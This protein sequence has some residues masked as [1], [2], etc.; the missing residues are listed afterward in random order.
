MNNSD[1]S[2]GSIDNKLLSLISERGWKGLNEMQEQS[3]RKIIKGDNVLIMAPT[4]YGKTEAAL[5]PIFS[6]ALK[7]SPEPVFLLYITPMRALINDLMRR[8]NWWCER[9]SFRVGRKH[10]EVPQSEKNVRLKEV[11]H[12]LITT[13]EGLEI[14]LDWAPKFREKLKKVK[15]V[16]IDEVHEIYQS[17]RGIQLAI[18]LKRLSSL[19]EEDFQRIVLSATIGNP[20]VLMKMFFDGSNRGRSLIKAQERKEFNIKISSSGRN[21]EDVVKTVLSSLEDK[22]IIFVDSRSLAE[23]IHEELEKLKVDN[24]YVHHS[25][26]GSKIKQEIEEKLKEGKVKAVISTKTLELGIDFAVNKVIM[27]HPP[28]SVTS[29]IQRIGRSNHVKEG[30]AKGEI[31][32]TSIGETLEAIAITELAKRGEIEKYNLIHPYLDVIGKEMLGIIIQRREVEEEEIYRF[33]SSISFLNAKVETL[34]E[35]LDLL[36]YCKIVEKE[37]GKIRIGKMFFKTWRLTKEKRPWQRSLSEFFSVMRSSD[38]F[39]IKSNGSKIGELDAVFVFKSIRM[40]DIIRVSGKYW[41]ITK[42]DFDKYTIEVVPFNQQGNVPIWRGES[43]PKSDKVAKEVGRII[44]MMDYKSE[45]EPLYSFYEKRGLSL[46]NKK[47]MIYSKRDKESIYSYILPEKVSNTL[48]HLLLDYCS[49]TQGPNCYARSSIYGFSISCE[50]DNPLKEIIKFPLKEIRR[51]MLRAIRRSPFFYI[52][53][54]EIKGNLGI[55]K[56]AAMRSKLLMSEAMKQTILRYFSISKTLRVLEEL[57]EGR[58]QIVEINEIDLLGE[59]VTY[60]QQ[61]KPWINDIKLQIYRIVSENDALNEREISNIIGFSE[62]YILL[63]LKDMRKPEEKMRLTYFID[64]DDGSIRWTTYE[65]IK[66]MTSTLFSSSFS[67]H[68]LDE[69]FKIKYKSLNG[70]FGEIIVK[71]KEVLNNPSQFIQYFPEEISELKV[72]PSNDPSYMAFPRFFYVN[73]SALP[74]LVLNAITYIQL[75]RPE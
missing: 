28:Q 7:S 58:I 68:N 74:Y 61:I 38:S 15:W 65:N 75:T 59:Q 25:S 36:S 45:L 20:E 34:K 37:N 27:V 54:K 3:Y 2:N 53:L 23:R 62:K 17:K 50:K 16:I 22:T 63:K 18:L 72:L 13:P 32:T 39:A 69:S 9:L 26:V 5:L 8:I 1:N 73:K 57:K 52:S 33:F 30:I 47:L 42:I 64:V 60:S 31:I 44:G 4:G 21:I 11:P 43:I 40:G 48:A 49:R 10:A 67:P 66:R 35:L 46:P 14:D 51:M 6:Q 12:I 29:F 70:E 19:A 41:K 56:T 55:N 71:V 24:I